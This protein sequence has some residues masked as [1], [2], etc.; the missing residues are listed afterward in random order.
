M[1]AAVY[2][3]P[4]KGLVVEQLD[5]PTPGERQLVV[6]VGACGV[7][8]TDLHMTS[9]EDM[10]QFDAGAIPG[11]EY[12]G[13]VVAVG[14]GTER[15]RVGD[16][17]TALAVPEACGHCV[18]C[19]AGLQQWCEGDDKVFGTGGAFAQYALLGEPLA[20][21][22]PESLEW[23]DGAL[24]EPLSVGGHGVELSGVRPGDRVVVLGAG[25]IGLAA[26]YWARRRG[27][28]RVVVAATSARR[29]PQALAMGATDFVITGG[30]PVTEIVEA[31]GGPPPLVFEAAGA[32]GAL[33]TAMTIVASRGTVIALGCLAKPDR[34][35]PAWPLFKEVRLQFSMTYSVGDYQRTI[36]ELT[37]KTVGPR[38]MVTG[39]VNLT[40][41]P[42]LFE[43]LRGRADHCKVVVDTQT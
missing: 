30:D 14:P 20:V 19:R 6:R 31:A 39:G 16:H 2:Q 29:Q 7:C 17:V 9:G 12:A 13:E 42:P 11:H 22:L 26:A 3:G 32:P 38:A 1:K 8:G 15:I 40:D 23:R 25:P 43:S 37:S 28:A 36:S 10:L 41:L 34:F 27:A 4:G 21:L 35:V 24:I 18:N 33:E 5:D